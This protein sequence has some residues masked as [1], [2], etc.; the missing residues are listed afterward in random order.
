MSSSSNM[1]KTQGTGQD[2]RKPS[3]IMMARARWYQSRGDSERPKTPLIRTMFDTH[4]V[5]AAAL[6]ERRADLAESLVGEMAP[7]R[8]GALRFGKNTAVMSK[9]WSR[10]RR[11]V[12]RS[13]SM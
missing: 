12:A 5:C 2:P 4:H 7:A 9:D 3:S 13:R 10:D 11:V 8:P 1:L 6:A